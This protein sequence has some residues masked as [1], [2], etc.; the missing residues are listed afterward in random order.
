MDLVAI[1]TVGVVLVLFIFA[2]KPVYENFQ[3]NT[4]TFWIDKLTGEFEMLYLTWTQLRVF[5]HP[6]ASLTPFTCPKD[7]SDLDT[8]LCYTPCRKGYHGVG[9]VCWVDSTNIGVGTPVG[10]EDCPAGWTNDGL[11][12]RQPISCG[13]DSWKP[14]WEPGHWECKGGNV[15]GRL[16][17]GGVCPGPGPS[18]HTDKVDGLCY[19]KCPKDM[20]NHMP[21]MPYLCYPGGDLSYGRGAGV[22]PHFLQF[23]G[24]S[25]YEFN[26]L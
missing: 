11:T 1:L 5:G 26:V 17:H 25:D 22:I 8:G 4:S 14:L 6:V 15:I 12:C 2:I 24:G 13:G 10:L 19:A 3:I 23:L 9:P 20:P 18:D 21:G 16:D 7:K